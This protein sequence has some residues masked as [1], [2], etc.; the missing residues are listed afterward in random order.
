MAGSAVYHAASMEL[1]NQVNSSGNSPLPTE[2]RTVMKVIRGFR[3]TLQ[4]SKASVK[5]NDKA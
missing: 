4:A 5:K 1:T 2:N 3:Q